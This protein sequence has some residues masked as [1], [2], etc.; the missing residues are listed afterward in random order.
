MAVTAARRVPEQLA[1]LRVL[2]AKAG[3]PHRT[4]SRMQT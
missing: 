4:T 3:S 2:A 1:N